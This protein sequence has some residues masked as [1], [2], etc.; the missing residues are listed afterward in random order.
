MTTSQIYGVKSNAARA[1]AKHGIK[2]DDLIAA[3]G[4]WCFNIPSET[5]PQSPVEPATEAVN[6]AHVDETPAA[7]GTPASEPAVPA[8][9]PIEWGGYDYMVVNGVKPVEL[10]KL[11]DEPAD[12]PVVT[13]P[14]KPAKR[15][16]KPKADKPAKPARPKAD[17][18]KAGEPAPEDKP[19]NQAPKRGKC[20]DLIAALK[21]GW[22]PMPKL[23]ERTGWLPHTMRGY[24]SRVAK[25][26]G[27]TLEYDKADGV[28]RYRIKV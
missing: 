9:E 7:A 14:A 27:W 11:A 20:A 24:I 12:V 17:K 18:P 6:G 25:A 5:S 4:G 13:A 15:Q 28:V 3:S 22:Q 10:A 1:A 16:R 23:L 26:E 2:R 8:D 19:K 21:S